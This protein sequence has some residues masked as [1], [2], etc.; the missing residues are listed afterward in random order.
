M[1]LKFKQQPYQTQAV[2]SVADC[3]KGQPNAAGLSYR[4]APGV[5]KSGAQGYTQKRLFEESGFK[6][7][8]SHCHTDVKAI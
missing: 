6:R 4:I 3:F 8:Y 1:K 7:Y 2:E 5:T